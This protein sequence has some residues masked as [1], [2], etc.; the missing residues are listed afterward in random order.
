MLWTFSNSLCA[1]SNFL[2]STTASSDWVLGTSCDLL[3]PCDL[4]L[5]LDLLELRPLGSGRTGC[6]LDLRCGL[7][8]DRYGDEIGETDRSCVAGR[9]SILERKLWTSERK[10]WICESMSLSWSSDAWISWK[11]E[12][13]NTC[14][15][16]Y[17]YRDERE[18]NDQEEHDSMDRTH[19]GSGI[20]ILLKVN[21][22]E[23]P[24]KAH[25]I[26]PM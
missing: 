23:L 25:S 9:L 16:D 5:D 24:S 19:V 10:S 22:V 7:P 4:D 15:N 26:L 13:N 21:C 20:K 8:L 6:D 1:T 12:N 18:T 17:L 2:P 3:L 11:R 14:K